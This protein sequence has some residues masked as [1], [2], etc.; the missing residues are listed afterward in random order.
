MTITPSTTPFQ[1]RLPARIYTIAVPSAHTHQYTAVGAVQMH[2][3]P[4]HPR[5]A[6]AYNR[7]GPR[8]FRI[9]YPAPARQT[10]AST[11]G[12]FECESLGQCTYGSCPSSPQLLAAASLVARYG[13]L[14]HLLPALKQQ[15]LP[16]QFLFHTRIVLAVA[17]SLRPKL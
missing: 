14:H 16:T 10:P 12:S 5:G 13:F 3:L 1:L 11:Q 7:Y 17:S 6:T 2:H 15:G 4:P 9:W 8:M